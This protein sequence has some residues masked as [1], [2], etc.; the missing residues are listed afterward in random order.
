VGLTSGCGQ[1]NAP[2]GIPDD[3]AGID[4]KLASITGLRPTVFD[5]D[6][7]LSRGFQA[8][9]AGGAP[10]AA[11]AD[12][13]AALAWLVTLKMTE[14]VW[15]QAT[16][17]RLTIANYFPRNQAASDLLHALAR[18]FVAS[19]FSLEALLVAIVSSDYFNRIPPDGAC[20][21]RPY[22]YPN[23]FDPWVTSEADP[24]RRLNGPGDAVT[25]VDGRT[26]IS[27]AAAALEWPDPPV[28]SRF[29]DYG[30]PA[31]A[32]RTCPEL[33]T[34]CEGPVSSCCNTHQLA[35]V[36]NGPLPLEELR[37]QRAVGLFLRS[38]ERGF[39][40]LSFQARLSWE[41]RYG[42]CTK[43][44]WV[45][46]DFIDRLAAA[47]VAT[48]GATARDVVAALKDRLIGEP[49]IADG[50]EAAALTAIVGDLAGP[51]SGAAYRLRRV[52][53]ALLGSP[54][55][56]LQGIAG[57]GGP[58]PLLTPAGAGYDAVCAGLAAGGI[59][60]PGLA[61]SCAGGALGLSPARTA[62]PA[63]APAAP[64]R[65]RRRDGGAT[66]ARAAAR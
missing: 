15:R 44:R 52:C 35:C 56:L 10:A 32:D 12:P 8:L 22:S 53:G 60:T 7:A 65:D 39:R 2:G 23:V 33:R 6:G 64:R 19:G 63:P 49:T 4:A 41:D 59:G 45:A 48:A 42:A 3:P 24:A 29:P 62:P 11:L 17:T 43:P 57:R 55:F 34:L 51:A 61:V 36:M 54:Q 47:G 66:A 30:E 58:R 37:F 14:D 28:P 27:A 9:R 20:G 18:S 16:G 38:S 46:E 1:W 25:A 5:L 40:G 31:C 50:P 13:D 21:A 26:L